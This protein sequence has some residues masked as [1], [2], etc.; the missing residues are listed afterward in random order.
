MTEGSQ[1]I[2]V[3]H[4]GVDEA[5]KDQDDSCSRTEGNLESDIS[6]EGHDAMM[7]DMER[8]HLIPL[9]PQDEEYGVQKIKDLES[10]VR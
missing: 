8:S 3:V 5:V 10:H 9:F 6:S 7:N 2:V 1:V 4:N